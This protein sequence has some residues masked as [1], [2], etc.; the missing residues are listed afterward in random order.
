MHKYSLI[1]RCVSVSL[2]VCKQNISLHFYMQLYL[3]PYVALRGRRKVLIMNVHTSSTQT[4]PLTEMQ[5]PLRSTS[6]TGLLCL[7]LRR[8]TSSWCKIRGMS[9]ILSSSYISITENK[10]LSVLNRALCH[11]DYMSRYISDKSV[12]LI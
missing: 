11:L 2:H 6:L 7:L 10:Y 5:I 4:G 3:Y 9:F 1:K 8:S 12:V